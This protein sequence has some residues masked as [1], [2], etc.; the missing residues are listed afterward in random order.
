[1][2]FIFSIFSCVFKLVRNANISHALRISRTK[3]IS[4][5]LSLRLFTLWQKST[6]LVKGRRGIF[7]K[8]YILFVGAAIGRPPLFINQ[9]GQAMLAPTQ[10]RRFCVCAVTFT[11]L[12]PQAVPPPLHKEGWL[13]SSISIFALRS[14]ATSAVRRTP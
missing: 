4:H 2:L 5:F 6:S 10:N 7:I 8:F 1:M 11:I 3:Y 14:K 12:P 13:V 9:N